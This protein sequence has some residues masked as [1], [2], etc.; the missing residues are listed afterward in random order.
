MSAT[1]AGLRASRQTGTVPFSPSSRRKGDCT[2]FPCLL[3]AL[4]PAI[5]SGAELRPSAVLIENF[6]SGIRQWKTND[7]LVGAER[8]PT[9]A[10]IY[11]VSAGAPKAAGTQAGLVEFA[12]AQKTWASV[13]LSVDGVT[14]VDTGCTGISLWLK[15]SGDRQSVSVVLR[16]YT[17]A[18][19]ETVDTSYVRDLPLSSA[20]WFS[21][22]LPFASFVDEHGRPIDEAHLRAVKLFQFVK[23]GSWPALR[24]TVDEMRAEVLPTKPA[25]TAP[26]GALLMDFDQGGRN[27]RL[28]HGVCLGSDAAKLLSD[29]AFATRV[30]GN[31]SLLGRSTIRVKLSDFYERDL[32]QLNTAKM[33]SVLAWIRS[34]GADPLLCLDEPLPSAGV[35]PEQGWRTFG[36]LCAYLAAVRKKEPGPRTYEIGS[37]PILSGQFKSIE[38]AT[39]AYDA[40]AAQ[41]LLADP[42]AQVGGMGFASAWDQHLGYFIE[43]ART[44]HFLSF[45]FYG[46]HNPVASDD[47]LFGVACAGRS[48]DLPNQL[49]PAEIRDLL[50][51]R[52]GPGPQIWITECALNSAR[53]T[54]GQ[55][56]DKRIRTTYGAAWMAAFSLSVAPY[57]DRVLWFKA[58][59]HGWGLLNDDG[60]AGTGF[61]AVH[62][63]T[64]FAPTG[65]TIGETMLAGSLTLLAPVSTPSGRYVVIA[66]SAASASL[67]VELRGTPP[68]PPVRLRRLDPTTPAPVFEPLSASLRQR[69]SLTG[70]G[71]AVIEAPVPR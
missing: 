36:A 39:A 60:S 4:L 28:Q 55:A 45:H 30:R 68:L 64:R 61:G 63:L 21:V 13:T 54:S 1:L 20:Q 62:L 6:E 24:F 29:Q 5:A 56:R 66:N 23:T 7:G 27:A 31:L 53:E 44:I 22:R 71:I 37:E 18:G 35:K 58:F 40:L 48:E 57:V 52:A 67:E 65:A 8:K 12:A 19:S 41:I 32:G 15:G 70:P 3:L 25:E 33:Q 16:S 17:K 14:W 38:A 50:S 49:S 59:G 47:A 2:G 10:A 11:A 34:C 9:L 69:L 43:H 51:R 46:A 26:V 42:A